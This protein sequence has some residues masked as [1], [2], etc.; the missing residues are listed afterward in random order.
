MARAPKKGGPGNQTVPERMQ[1]ERG[2]GPHNIVYKFLSLLPSCASRDLIIKGI[3]KTLRAALRERPSPSAHWVVHMRDRSKQH[4]KDFYNRADIETITLQ[5]AGQKLLSKPNCINYLL[6]KKEINII[7]RF[8]Q[9]PK[10]HNIQNVQDTI[11]NYFAYEES[12]KFQLCGKRQSTDDNVEM[13][14]MLKLP[15]KYFNIVI[16]KM[17]SKV[18]L[19]TLEM[20]KKNRKSQQRNKSH[21]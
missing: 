12:R 9:G 7:H 14:E 17:L 11:Q 4:C 16:V 15:N 6:L 1:R 13:T 19:N 18:R 5:K 20:N 21:M 3:P 2:S 10:F 8:K